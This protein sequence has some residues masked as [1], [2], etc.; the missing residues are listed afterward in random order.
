MK[1]LLDVGFSDFS[2]RVDK[3][4]GEVYYKILFENSKEVIKWKIF[5]L[6]NE[7]WH[8]RK[9]HIIKNEDSKVLEK[10]TGTLSDLINLVNI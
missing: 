3:C 5:P 2:N 4:G 8:L 7:Q 1:K 10:Y 9:Y 6:K